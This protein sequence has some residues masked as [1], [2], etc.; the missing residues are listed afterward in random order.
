ML[1]PKK[2][3]ALNNWRLFQCRGTDGKR[4]A[5]PKGGSWQ[6]KKHHVKATENNLTRATSGA[7]NLAA[8]IPKGVLVVDIDNKAGLTRLAEACNVPKLLKTTLAVKTGRGYHLWY[9]RPKNFQIKQLKNKIEVFQEIDLKAHGGY[10]VIPPSKHRN[11]KHY[12]QIDNGH[13]TPQKLPRELKKYLT[14]CILESMGE[15]SYLTADDLEKLDANEKDTYLSYEH[16]E[17]VLD[18]L[19]PESFRNMA[20]EFVPLLLSVHHTMRGQKRARAMFIEWARGDNAYNTKEHIQAN[21]VMWD[22]AKL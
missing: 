1:T 22:T 6:D 12:K 14:R 21:K 2:L 17:E 15:A 20:L 19:P 4:P 16:L 18:A 5:I 7:K 3:I 8:V 13:D 9:K 10:M 11:G